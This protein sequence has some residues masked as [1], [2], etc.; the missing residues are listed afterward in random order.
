[1]VLSK[2]RFLTPNMEQYLEVIGRLERQKDVV[3]VKDIASE[4]EV[5]MPSVTAALKT[6]AAEGLVA[7]SP[8]EH[9]RLTV[10]G[11]AAAQHVQRRHDTLFRFLTEVLCVPV[12][13][14]ERDACEMEH[15]VGAHTLER[16]IEF[17][18]LVKACPYTERRYRMRRHAQR[19]L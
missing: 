19:N 10:A 12:H 4:M 8:Y 9:V 14:A 17:V 15:G 11:K 1:M 5:T 16:L 7:H 13:E 18:E 3:R 6:L 2:K